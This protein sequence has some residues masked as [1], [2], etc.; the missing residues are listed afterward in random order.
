MVWKIKHFA[1]AQTIMSGLKGDCKSFNAVSDAPTAENSGN[2]PTDAGVREVSCVRRGETSFVP[3]LW[4]FGS[5]FKFMVRNVTGRLTTFD[6]IYTVKTTNARMWI[7]PSHVIHYQLVSTA[8]TVIIRVIYNI[9]RS[10]NKLLKCISE[11]LTVTH[12]SQTS[13]TVIE[14]QF[15]N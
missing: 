2:V 15:I 11:P 6:P 13:Y 7:V 14:Y 8:A 4:C 1:C 9:T 12:M 10:P 3:L 5:W